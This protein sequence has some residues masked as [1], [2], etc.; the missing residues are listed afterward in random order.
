MGVQC[1]QRD[2]QEGRLPSS[3]GISGGH[4]F[5]TSHAADTWC[6]AG[7]PCGEQGGRDREERKVFVSATWICPRAL[8]VITE[9]HGSSSST[10]SSLEVKTPIPPPVVSLCLPINDCLRSALHRGQKGKGGAGGALLFLAP[11]HRKTCARLRFTVPRSAKQRA[12][13]SAQVV[14]K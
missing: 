6:C 1:R 13:S 2:G 10:A 4:D 7:T 12:S 9:K 14:L 3:A 5:K 11:L 8:W